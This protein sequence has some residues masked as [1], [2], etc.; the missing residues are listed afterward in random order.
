MGKKTN[1]SVSPKVQITKISKHSSLSTSAHVEKEKDAKTEFLKKKKKRKEISKKSFL[2]RDL[3][4][5]E[6]ED[7]S[8]RSDSPKQ[9][10]SDSPRNEKVESPRREKV[11]SPR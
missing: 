10:K 8:D 1:T 7:S 2:L 4:S 5:D 3:E 6:D 11:E 9:D